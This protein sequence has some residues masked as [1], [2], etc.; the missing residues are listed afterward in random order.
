MNAFNKAVGLVF[1]PFSPDTGFVSPY[2]PK[3]GAFQ[4][5]RDTPPTP[6]KFPTVY[7]ND[8]QGNSLP[9]PP[10]ADVISQVSQHMFSGLG[11]SMNNNFGKGFLDTM[12]TI[13]NDMKA[14]GEI[15][16]KGE[17][18]DDQKK[19]E[20]REKKEKQEADEEY[21]KWLKYALTFVS[22]VSGVV[23][24]WILHN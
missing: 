7:T 3:Y 15:V 12:K 18:S 16:A 24:V 19:R 11:Q 14:A 9:V 22:I 6:Q 20:D 2:G 23:V 4:G 21:E 17:T 10:P 5:Q 1:K 8:I 13:G